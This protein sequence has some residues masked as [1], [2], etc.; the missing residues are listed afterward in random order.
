MTAETVSDWVRL[1]DQL[2]PPAHAQ[3]WDSPGLQVGNPDAAV[4]AVSV[5]LDVTE[6]V[7]LEAV[8]HGCNLIIAHHPLLFRP[9]PSL[10]PNS[11]SGRLAL[12]AAERGVAIFAAHTNFDA[13]PDTTSWTALN[14]LGITTS[15]PIGGDDH[16]RSLGLLGTLP[17]PE[18]L[19]DVFM[20]VRNQLPSP[21][22]RLGTQDPHRLVQHIACVGG[23]GASLAE[24]ARNAGADVFITG[25]V[26]HH[27]A[28]DA[29][30]MGLAIIDAGHYGTESPAMATMIDH[31]RHHGPSYGCHARVLASSI[32]TDPWSTTPAL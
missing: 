25:D 12:L 4:H 6:A 3:D 32:C 27:E 15:H 20:K 19:I 21:H 8:E 24:Q 13:R 23:S 14:T 16:E 2:Y 31:L 22:A 9:L 29:I 30:T 26:S 7:I 28:L 1:L 18:P 10:S 11:A 17:Q 5:A